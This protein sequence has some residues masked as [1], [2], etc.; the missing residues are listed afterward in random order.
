MYVLSSANL[1]FMSL[2][3]LPESA[4]TGS[5]VHLASQLAFSPHQHFTRRA[6]IMMVSV[7]VAQRSD[8]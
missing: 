3:L 7:R 2:L 8:I 4:Q 6:A 1:C 5:K